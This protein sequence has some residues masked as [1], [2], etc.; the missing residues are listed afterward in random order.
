MNAGIGS[1]YFGMNI[2]AAGNVYVCSYAGNTVNVYPPGSSTASRTITGL[3]YPCYPFSIPVDGS[4]NIFVPQYDGAT[5]EYSRTSGNTPIRT[6]PTTYPVATLDKSGNLYVVNFDSTGVSVY[7]PGASTTPAFQFNAG[8]DGPFGVV[9]DAAGNLYVL[10][11]TGANVT[12][13]KPPFSASS[14]VYKTFGSSTYISDPYG[15]NVDAAGNVYVASDS[16]AYSVSEFSQA[17]PTTNVRLLAAGSYAGEVG[18]D[19]LQN[20]YVPAYSLNQMQVYAPGT[21]TMPFNTWAQNSSW[22]EAVWP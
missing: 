9:F 7:R 6:L 8:M 18:I 3:D 4:G 5:L 14:T 21:G 11:Y 19:Q 16:P 10:N 12:E 15:F 13:Y 20:V 1:D 2:D 22:A 17:A